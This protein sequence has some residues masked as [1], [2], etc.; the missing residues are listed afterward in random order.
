MKRS[1]LSILLMFS[2]L[3]LFPRAMAGQEHPQACQFG[4]IGTWRSSTGGQMNPTLER[5]APNGVMTELT[6]NT[7]GKGPEWEPTGK[8]RY[9]LDNAKGPKA[10]I[11]TKV[12]KGNQLSVGAT[13]EIRTFD[14]GMFVTKA[15]DDAGGELTR[16]TRIDPYRYFVVLAAGKGSPGFGAPGFAVLIK[17]DGV[18]TQTDALGEYPV[19][20]PRQRYPEFG[21]ISEE[22]RKQFD[23]EPVNDTGSMLRLEV[24]AGPYHRALEVMKSWQRR[25]EE[26]QT[27]YPTVSYLD[28][29]IYLNQLTSSLNETGVLQWDGGRPCSETIKL[30][31]LTWLVDDPIMGKHNLPQT[32]YYL[33]KALRELNGSLHLSDSQFHAALGGDRSAAVAISSR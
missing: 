31:K 5:F 10:M 16:W 28:N 30:R 21:E 20:T 9:T 11:L 8:S 19:V 26:N 17:T 1:A 6:R 23:Q 13:L 22:I 29:A 27:L 33:F 4:I 7:S 3:I 12:E 25:V 32:P 24:T 15:A 2:L 14:D 18:H